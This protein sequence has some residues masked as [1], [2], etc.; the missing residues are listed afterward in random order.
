MAVNAVVS[1]N[2]TNGTQ[3]TQN[4]TVGTQKS[5]LE[6]NETASLIKEIADAEIESEKIKKQKRLA[7]IALNKATETLA[8]NHKASITQIEKMSERL[9][10]KARLAGKLSS[11]KIKNVL[12][13]ASLAEMVNQLTADKNATAQDMELIEY[14]RKIALR[15]KI[16]EI[17]RKKAIAELKKS[18]AEKRRKVEADTI[19]Q[20]IEEEKALKKARLE[21]VQKFDKER[22]ERKDSLVN[23]EVEMRKLQQLEL[24]KFNKELEVER[25][26]KFLTIESTQRELFNMRKAEEIKREIVKQGIQY[27]KL[28]QE[29]NLKKAE[30]KARMIEDLKDK[31]V[32]LMLQKEDFMRKRKIESAEL[33]SEVMTAKREVAEAEKL[34]KKAIRSRRIRRVALRNAQIKARR[35]QIRYLKIKALKD[36]LSKKLLAEQTIY[37]KKLDE[38]TKIKALDC[39]ARDLLK[40]LKTVAK[41]YDEKSAETLKKI[42]AEK[43]A[44]LIRKMLQEKAD[45]INEKRTLI[46]SFKLKIHKLEEEEMQK[47]MQL[48]GVE[49]DILNQK[50]LAK[51]MVM[52]RIRER[53]RQKRIN[54]LKAKLNKM[55][56]TKR[57]LLWKKRCIRFRKVA[58]KKMDEEARK[59]KIARIICGKKVNRNKLTKCYDFIHNKYHNMI[60]KPGKPGFSCPFAGKYGITKCQP[61]ELP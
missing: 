12:A 1:T 16:D 49:K 38:Q 36:V 39:K 45:E 41:V 50:T 57:E 11:A 29:E 55:F 47:Q 20:Q 44:L 5:V 14:N 46:N 40:R 8:K 9:E 54:E 23:K 19:K 7:E 56:L 43:K 48:S 6:Q 24:E 59:R 37:K 58:N 53:S 4:S 3:G 35:T 21:L 60:H 13:N 61:I 17:K 10:T 34:A 28:L 42:R 33:K 18:L 31:A 25:K 27:N 52:K 26:M 30:Q 15:D 2:G 22:K 51:I 32:T